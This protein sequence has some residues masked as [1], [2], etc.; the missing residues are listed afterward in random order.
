MQV[1]KFEA[2]TMKEALE[3]VKSQL[4]PDAII[5]SARDNSRGYGLMGQKSVEVTAAIAEE[6]LKKKLLAE[7]KLTT[8]AKD[9]FLKSPARVQ[10]QFIDG[11]MGKRATPAPADQKT[12]R[13]LRAAGATI[14]GANRPLTQ[15]RYADISDGS[16]QP[17]VVGVS[18]AY[19]QNPQVARAR[20]R[21]A[22]K[23]AFEAGIETFAPMEPKAKANRPVPM[24]TDRSEI[25][26]LKA[27][28]ENLKTLLNQ[29][30]NVP[31]NFLNLH[32]GANAGIPF[33][34]SPTFDKLVR[35]GFSED[36]VIEILKKAQKELNPAD[37]KKTS[38]VEAWVVHFLLSHIQLVDNRFQ[39]F[40]HV[41]LGPAGQ[42]KTTS[43]VKFASEL[44]LNHKKKIAVLTLDTLKVGAADQ[45]KIY[46]Q[47]LNVPFAV[48]SQAS[49]WK[50]LEEKLR[51]YDH[52]LVDVPGFNFKN[53]DEIN[54]IRNLLPPV[55]DNNRRL[56]YVQSVLAKDEDAF[57][58][59]ERYRVFQ[60][61]DTIF[62]GLD[63]SN[64][65]GIIYNFQKQF[66]LPLHSFAT[67]TKL[68]EDFEA[69]SKERF[70]DLVF[71]ISK[72]K[73]GKA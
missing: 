39:G 58:I 5:L 56:H 72:L 63:E 66:A 19:G 37:L 64:Q 70:V 9:R 3:M 26:S 42:G 47:I 14:T 29:F 35:A 1:K 71:K 6:H 2:K 69:A 61:H 32:P 60:Y 46:A 54:W 24:A 11:A 7:K 13:P 53:A 16:T 43:L 52:I 15:Q 45:L 30:Q 23:Q 65:H 40:Y 18:T 17:A 67:G 27:E 12:E 28:I 4:G 21:N 31:Q 51:Q 33:E 22:A 34:L 73:K 20:I 25:V 59:A 8:E 48:I 41:F 68:P 44:V 55:R 36:N 50:I 57:E 38:H 62:T 10:K 49:Q